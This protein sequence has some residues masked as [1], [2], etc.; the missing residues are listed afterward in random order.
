MGIGPGNRQNHE[1]YFLIFEQRRDNLPPMLIFTT[2][3]GSIFYF[4]SFHRIADKTTCI[5]GLHLLYHGNQFCAD[6]SYRVPDAFSQL[7]SIHAVHQQLPDYMEATLIAFALL[8]RKDFPTY[9]Q[10]FDVLS[11]K[12]HEEFGGIGGPKVINIYYCPYIKIGY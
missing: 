12:L 6:G 11:E 10:V 7:Y 2:I 1:D 9:R 3:T 5:L 8:A 4:H